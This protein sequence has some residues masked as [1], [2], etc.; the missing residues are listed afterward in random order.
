MPRG[1]AGAVQGTREPGLLPGLPPTP[2]A[3]PG[4]LVSGNAT[5]PAQQKWGQR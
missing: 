4:V 2:E 5:V 1:T 3:A